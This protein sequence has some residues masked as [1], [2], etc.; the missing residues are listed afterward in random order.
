[1][2]IGVGDG[3]VVGAFFGDGDA[4]ERFVLIA[5]NGAANCLN[6]GSDG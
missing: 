1:V 2:T 6:R 4:D 5:D 3:N